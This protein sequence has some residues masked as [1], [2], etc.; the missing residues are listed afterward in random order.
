MNNIMIPGE[1][2]TKCHVLFSK[3]KMYCN[4]LKCQWFGEPLNH[5][6]HRE[7]LEDYLVVYLQQ[8]LAMD[9]S[10]AECWGPHPCHHLSPVKSRMAH[11]LTYQSLRWGQPGEMSTVWSS[12]P[13]TTDRVWESHVADTHGEILV[14]RYMCHSS[15]WYALFL[16]CT[17]KQIFGVTVVS[18]VKGQS[19]WH[20]VSFLSVEN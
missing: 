4:I 5:C 8:W 3:R 9:H 19:K 12:H 13:Q 6:T 17:W 15:L 14:P 20:F 1:S 18:Q 10:V 7:G 16:K 2:T 11:P